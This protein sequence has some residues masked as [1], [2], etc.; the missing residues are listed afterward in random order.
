LKTTYVTLVADESVHPE[1]DSALERVV[2][3]LD[4]FHTM[5][6]GD[7]EVVSDKG[8]FEKNAQLTGR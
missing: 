6:I 5:Y 2:R 1:Y 7:R 4:Q 8:E 3:N